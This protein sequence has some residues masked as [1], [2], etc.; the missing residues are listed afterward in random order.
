MQ[1]NI[2]Y[3]LNQSIV[4][5]TSSKESFAWLKR[6]YTRSLRNDVAI[7]RES[8]FHLKVVD[9]KS[10]SCCQKL[11]PDSFCQSLLLVEVLQMTCCNDLCTSLALLTTCNM[12]VAFLAV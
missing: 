12:Y 2:E 8:V 4:D 3:T 9:E 6:I 5:K 10:V 7:F 1:F 11:V